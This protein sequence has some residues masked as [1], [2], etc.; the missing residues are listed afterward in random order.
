MV[1]VPAI[2]NGV[3]YIGSSDGAFSA[4]DAS[5][6]AVRWQDQ[7]SG[8][9]EAAPVVANG[10][11]YVST[12]SGLVALDAST[13]VLRWRPQPGSNPSFSSPV[14]ANGVV[15][16]NSEVGQ[17]V[18]AL[19]AGTGAV[20]WQF[21]APFPTAGEFP[22]APAV[23]H[24]VV[25]AVFVHNGAFAT[26]TSSLYALDTTTGAVRWSVHDRMNAYSA[27]AVADGVIYLSALGRAVI[28]LDART[29]AVRWHFSTD[30]AGGSVPTVANGVV[31]IGCS[32]GAVDALDAGT[33]TQRWRFQT[34][35]APPG[36]WLLPVV[37]NGTVYVSSGTALYALTS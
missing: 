22:A 19:D 6:G 13:G 25:Y 15:Y 30:V 27:P 26:P 18:Y 5:T 8:W 17:S 16:A 29:G 3:V 34:D 37:A 24:G 14:V 28:A 23:E 35:L 21:T 32:D 33:G 31:Y 36:R 10:V 4:L 20:R 9:Q 11:V 2:A 12:T 1:A 7:I